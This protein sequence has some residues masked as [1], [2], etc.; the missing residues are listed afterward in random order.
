[1]MNA[2]QA[3]ATAWATNHKTQLDQFKKVC[4]MIE[5]AANKGEYMIMLN[6]QLYPKVE[7]TLHENG[8]TTGLAD[9][10]HNYIIYWGGEDA[11]DD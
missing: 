3:R 10:T 5:D 8:Y 9:I 2:R 11:D 7:E 6:E 1:M 4:K